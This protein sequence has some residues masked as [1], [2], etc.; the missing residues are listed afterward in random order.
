MKNIIMVNTLNFFLNA[1]LQQIHDS[2]EE[3]MRLFC[4]MM[5]DKKVPEKNI[6]AFEKIIHV[7]K[8]PDEKI[9]GTLMLDE[10]ASDQAIQSIYEEYNLEPESTYIITLNELSMEFTAKMRRKYNAKGGIPLEQIEIFRDKCLMKKIL[11]ANNVRAPKYSSFDWEKCDMSAA[12]SDKNC[13]YFNDLKE[14][15]GLP[16]IIKPTKGAGA[17][18]VAKI[19][20]ESDFLSWLE[21]YHSR[22][23]GTKSYSDFDFQVEEF[24]AGTL[25]HVDSILKDGELIW[26]GMCEYIFPCFEFLQGKS[27]GSFLMRESNPLFGALSKF[28]QDCLKAFGNLNGIYHMEVFLQNKDPSKPEKSLEDRLVFLEVGCRSAGAD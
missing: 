13:G 5:K 24:I 22:Q 6:S 27:L 19:Y 2:S 11:H 16:F 9:L 20:D 10:D 8:S 7:D 12:N 4:I 1:D 18:D 23:H 21:K 15:I 3:K 26:I 17:V 28:H 25:F 14:S